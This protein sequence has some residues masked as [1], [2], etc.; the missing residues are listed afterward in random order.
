MGGQIIE[1]REELAGLISKS[2]YAVL[3]MCDG[4][5]PYAVP[6]NAA[7]DGEYFYLHSGH[8]GRKI[9]VLRKNPEVFLTFV[10][11]AEFVQRRAGSSCWASMNFRSACVSGTAE[12]L[13]EDSDL[14]ERRRGLACLARHFGLEGLPMKEAVLA[15][16]TV[17]R[18]KSEKIIAMQKPGKPG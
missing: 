4:V 1:S 11:E 15:K 17:I 14:E 6:I 7:W 5:A 10:P 16:T 12:I 2:Q 13:G 18:I 9:D 8:K 3:S